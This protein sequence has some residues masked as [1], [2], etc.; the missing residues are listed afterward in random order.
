[1]NTAHVARHFART[2]REA[3]SARLV[4]A[5][6][7]R[8]FALSCAVDR[9]GDAGE[10]QGAGIPRTCTFQMRSG[11]ARVTIRAICKTEAR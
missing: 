3:E 5:V 7:V 9:L 2:D 4:E 6:R 8:A 11:L 1:M 10:G